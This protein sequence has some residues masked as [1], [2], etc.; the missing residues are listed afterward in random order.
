[1]EPKRTRIAMTLALVAVAAVV[2]GAVIA[3]PI[4]RRQVGL[5]D[6]TVWVT[7]SRHAAGAR[8]NVRLREADVTLRMRG[9]EPDVVQHES[10]TVLV[11]G[12]RMTPVSAPSGRRGHAVPLPDDAEVMTA[13]GTVAVLDRD[14]GEVRIAP[15]GGTRGLEPGTSRPVMSLGRGGLAAVDADGMTWGFRPSDGMVLVAASPRARAARRDGSLT[16]GRPLAATSFTVVDGMPVVAAAGRVLFRSGSA[17]VGAERPILQE[18][19]VDGLQ[20]GWVAAAG[21]DGL[22][23][24][25]LEDGAIAERSRFDGAGA[26]AA[27]P[28]SLGGCVHAAWPRRAANYLRVCDSGTAPG[29]L[30]TLRGVDPAGRLVLRANHGHVVVNDTSGGDVWEPAR[31]ATALAVGWDRVS[32]RGREAPDASSVTSDRQRFAATCSAESGA[33]AAADDRAGIRAGGSRLIDVLRNDRRSDCSVLRIVDVSDPGGDV[34]A[35]PSH[36]GRFLQVSAGPDASSSSFSYRV[37]DGRGRSAVA[38][39]SLDV[40]G[41]GNRPPMQVDG[42]SEAMLERGAV[43][44]FPALGG[45]D[46]PDGDALALVSATASGHG[47]PRVVP[48]PDG[49]VDVDASQAS[50]GRYAVTLTVSD[51]RASATGTMS[52]AVRPEATL[53][54]DIDPVSVTTRMGETADVDLSAAVRTTGSGALRLVSV[55]PPD[56]TVAQAG[57]EGLSLRVRGTRPGSAY[58]PYV[59]AQGDRRA[60]GLLRVDTPAVL[61][62][63]EAP[64]AVDDVVVLDGDGMGVVSPASNDVDLSGGVP[65]VVAVDA[66]AGSG[67]RAGIGDDGRVRLAASRMPAGPVT[68]RYTIVADSGRARG[69]IVVHPPAAAGGVAPRPPSPTAHVRAGGS[70][71]VRV[72]EDDA[73]SVRLDGGGRD[74]SV[75]DGMAFVDGGRI[76]LLAPRTPGRYATGYEVRMPDGAQ[77]SGTVTFV[78]HAADAAAKSPPRP[79]DVTAQAKAGATVAIPIDLEGIDEDG[80]DVQLLGLGTRTPRR[81]RVLGVDAGRLLY[82]AYGDA[83][84]SDEFSYAVEDWTGRRAQARVRVA[85]RPATSAQGVMAR[86]D[87]VTLR[88][89]AV[90]S[91]PV[92][93]NDL[94]GDAG[95]LTLDSTLDAQGVEARADPGSGIIRL[96]A[97]DRPCRLSVSYTVRDRSGL[98]DTATLAVT[99]DPHAPAEPPRAADYRV[100]VAASVGRRR[101]EVDLSELVRFPD[102]RTSGIRARVPGPAGRH[103]RIRGDG[104]GMT[105]SI[106]LTDRPRA[107]PYT[108]DDGGGGPSATAFVHVP[109][110]G[111][112][113]PMRRPDAPRLRVS[114]G[115]TLDIDVDEQVRVGVGKRARVDVSHPVSVTGAR[116]TVDVVDDGMLRF[117]ADGGRGGPASL[118]FVARDGGEG[119][120]SSSAVIALPLEV[121]GSGPDLSLSVPA[122]D[123]EAGGSVRT[124]DLRELTGPTSDAAGGR[125]RVS[126]AGGAAGH[127]VSATVDGQGL[128]RVK[129]DEDARPGSHLVVPLSASAG[130]MS[131]RTSMEVR[132]VSSLRP[133]AHVAARQATVHA[134]GS[135]VVDVLEGAGNP[136]PGSPLSVASCRTDGVAV[137]VSCPSSGRLGISA[138]AGTSGTAT[139]VAVVEDATGDATRRV[140]AVL[141]VAVIDRPSAPRLAPPSPGRGEVRLAWAPSAANGSPVVEYRVSFS[142]GGPTSFRSCATDTAC[143]VGGLRNGVPYRF[144]VQARNGAGWSEPSS[145]VTAVPDAV[146]PAPSP[147]RLKAGHRT[148]TVSWTMPPYDGSPVDRYVVALDGLPAE[149]TVEGALSHTFR[150]DEGSIRQG[151]SVGATVRA[152]SRAGSGPPGRAPGAVR[153]YGTPAPPAVTA[154]VSDVRSSL[155]PGGRPDAV[156]VEVSAVAGDMR[157]TSCSAVVLSLGDLRSPASCDAMSAVVMVP[158]SAA[159]RPLTPQAEIRTD[160]G[161]SVRAEGPALDLSDVVGRGSGEGSHVSA[162]PRRGGTS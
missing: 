36:G 77:G 21:D 62:D 158:A 109:A 90:A 85:I 91:V 150:L 45:F 41:D 160:Q 152:V 103:A 13:G 146:P 58:V 33:V 55:S 74:R 105:M 56:G 84:G 53:A 15:A 121:V 72:S 153:P 120:V 70:V 43:A 59:V 67:L 30:R 10:T 83:S 65:A 125:R 26:S 114:P 24:V 112:F 149:A 49:M 92:T 17:R 147:I 129:A 73:A 131:L 102:G 99:V 22:W 42:A 76:R 122:V 142:A 51:G 37:D 140:S 155:S 48:H 79:R 111:A 35:A 19:P 7:S 81:G 130:G 162:R 66:P 126:Y 95:P 47:A 44:S 78:V 50:A 136:F 54:A 127:G 18:P 107:V 143:T 135:V 115:G 31:S 137:R 40:V 139:V 39:V 108:V 86:D 89:G 96:V 94:A 110:Y 46:D 124:V 148:V 138:D 34:R 134:G 52:V 123:V 28:V 101:V 16:D 93:A 88:P 156:A 11:E 8:L 113:P 132:V 151:L 75:A 57:R 145:A 60:T 9:G 14:T 4:A 25:S 12:S 97:P 3:S 117:V 116:G 154:R 82:E 69:R 98:G 6:G 61:P 106:D 80:D 27:R 157:N 68:V 5:D 23:T 100:P 32:D 128:L 87:R 104:Q 141:T 64:T 133:L 161:L 119:E 159:E 118:V 29:R 38:T 144:S 20:S 1:M 63:P 71:S 2:A